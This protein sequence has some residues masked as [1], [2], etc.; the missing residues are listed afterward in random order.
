MAR[1]GGALVARHVVG[2]GVIAAVVAA[3]WPA[4]AEQPLDPSATERQARHD[5]AR[6]GRLATPLPGTP[7]TDQPLTR[8]H[9]A[10]LSLG[11]PLMV[12][13]FKAESEFELWVDKNGT[14]IRFATYPIC[15]W[16]GTLG[17][18]L[19]EGDRQTPEGFYTLTEE[20]LHNGGRWRRSLN[21]GYPNVF[22]RANGRTGSAIL[23]HG[24]CDSSGCFAMT[25]PVSAELYDLVVAAFRGGQQHIPVHV[26]P[27]RMTDANLAARGDGRWNGFWDDL[28]A[29]YESFERTRLPPHVSVC[30]RR[31]Q[32][33]D[34]MRGGSDPEGVELCPGDIDLIP[35]HLRQAPRENAGAPQASLAP[36][37]PPP[38]PCATARASCRKWVALHDRRAA[39]RT[40][41]RHN[42][43]PSKRSAVR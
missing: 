38:P 30:G 42:T 6:A 33:R 10:G 36:S 8:L 22:D 19:R 3:C 11:A 23:V 31:Y 28:K 4:C 1:S 7:D 37:P 16:S 20:Q 14:F 34:A 43:T 39:S 29:G 32:I 26:F 13:I 18:K 21:I 27:F 35:A 17:P 2:L 15:Y 12:R 40:F 24:G 41:A 25:N 9:A 5:A